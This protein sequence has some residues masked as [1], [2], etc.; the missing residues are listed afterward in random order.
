MQPTVTIGKFRNYQ[1]IVSNYLQL[2]SYCLH[3]VLASV[4]ALTRN[5]IIG[6][7]DPLQVAAFDMVGCGLNLGPATG[8]RSGSNPSGRD[9]RPVFATFIN[10]TDLAQQ[11]VVG[12]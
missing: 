2:L 10:R 5:S 6:I 4:C 11:P 1:V 9:T 8:N 3:G 12:S 7:F